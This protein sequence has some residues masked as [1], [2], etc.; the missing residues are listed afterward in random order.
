MDLMIIIKWLTDFSQMDGAK[1]PSI[2]TLM[3]TMCLNFGQ[4]QDGSTPLWSNQALLMQILL[5]VSLICVPLMLFVKPVW[6]HKQH[7]QSSKRLIIEE[8]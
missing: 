5:S 1:P 3:I 4:T 7:G 6:E 2:I 8:G